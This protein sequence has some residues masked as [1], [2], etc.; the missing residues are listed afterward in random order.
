M[1][2]RFKIYGKTEEKL[3]SKGVTITTP[4]DPSATLLLFGEDK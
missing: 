4:Q 2:I 1:K 3:L